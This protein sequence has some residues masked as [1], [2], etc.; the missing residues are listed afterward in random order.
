MLSTEEKTDI[1]FAGSSEEQKI[2]G[3]IFAVMRAQGRFMSSDA[4][5]RV[6]L[7]SARAFLAQTAG[8]DA[9]GRVERVLELNAEVFA[10]SD[11]DGQ[12]IIET[13]RAGRAPR[14]SG[15]DLTHSFD[16]RF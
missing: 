9:A 11:L 7:V 14:P 12:T 13:T 1:A 10:V 6:S 8:D 5:I 3:E 15:I 4:P 16:R 2:A